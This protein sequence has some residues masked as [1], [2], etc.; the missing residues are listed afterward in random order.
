MFDLTGK[1]ALVTGA[2]GGIG[3][4]IASQLHKAGANIVLSGTN[5]ERLQAKAIE[6]GDRCKILTANLSDKG[7]V[8]QL[9]KDADAAFD[10]GLDILVCN[11]GITRDGLAMRMSD[12]DWQ[13]VI[14]VNLS[15][16]FY[17]IRSTLKGMFK[18]RGGRIINIGSVV[19]T[20]GNP[21]QINY[22][23][24]KAGVIGLS[25]SLAIEAAPRGV[26]VNVIAPG[27]IATAMTDKLNEKQS[28]AILQKIPA[29]R[30][31]ASDDIAAAALYL[32]SNEAAYVTGQTIHVNG[33][34]LM[35]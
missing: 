32:A 19:G 18:K 26:T 9:A 12:E 5:K 34:M 22:C 31:G 24:A 33:G 2:S 28:E 8:Q 23:A 29:G 10:G 15:S 16:V 3:G 11:A 21:G 4:A 30:L 1:N 14:D 27:F 7:Q 6:L 25:K 35:V 20:S 17:L 13:D